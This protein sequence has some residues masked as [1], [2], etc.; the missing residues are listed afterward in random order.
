MKYVYVQI[1]YQIRIIFVSA[2][3]S[4]L[5]SIFDPISYSFVNS[6]ICLKNVKV[7]NY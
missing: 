1:N 7:K 6:E 3:L 4:Y 2:M 5:A